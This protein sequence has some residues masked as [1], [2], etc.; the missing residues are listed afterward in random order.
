MINSKRGETQPALPFAHPDL[1]FLIALTEATTDPILEVYRQDFAVDLKS[2]QEPVTEADRRANDLIVRLVHERY[3]DDAL[4]TE[5]AGFDA[6][7]DGHAHRVWFVDPIDG[8]KE[9]IRKNGE[10]AVQIALVCDRRLE[11]GAI[12]RPTTGDLY[13]AARGK[14]CH[15]RRRENGN[16]TSW[17]RLKCVPSH[18]G[19][20]IVA[21]SRSHPSSLAQRAGERVGLTGEFRHGSVGL[22]LMAM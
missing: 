20:L 4:L 14:G 13:V 12:F 1:A 15:V 10:F 7:H 22:K 2:G 18:A 8:T 9:F 17:Q 11:L 3:P 5:E 21:M 19:S 16:D 6:G